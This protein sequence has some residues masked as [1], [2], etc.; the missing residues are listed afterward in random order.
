MSAK[1]G[2]RS[3]LSYGD[4]ERIKRSLDQERK[5]LQGYTEGVPNRYQKFID[6][7]VR[8]DPTRIRR[9]I[10]KL[11]KILSDGSP[12]SL[13]KSEKTAREKMIQQDREW[14]QGH[15]VSRKAYHI[16]WRDIK[17]GR[18][19]KADYDKAVQ[20]CVKEQ[21]PEFQARANRYKNNMR[22]IDPDNPGSSNIETIRPE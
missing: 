11:E 14:L 15:M 6:E 21:S 7:K 9:N 4:R 20:G 1:F 22:E 2:R 18:A 13:S 5:R 10:G 17:E 3:V 16:G 19:T 12:D 8:E